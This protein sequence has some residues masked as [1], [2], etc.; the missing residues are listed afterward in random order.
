MICPN[1]KNNIPNDTILCPNCSYNVTVDKIDDSV[2][3]IMKDK[4]SKRIEKNAPEVLHAKPHKKYIVLAFVV[5]LLI[6][7]IMI[8]YLASDTGGYVNYEG[9]LVDYEEVERNYI[10]IYEYKTGNEIKRISNNHYYNN[11]EDVPKTLIISE[12]SSKEQNKNYS[13]AVIF[14]FTPYII[15]AI[16]SFILDIRYKKKLKE[17][18]YDMS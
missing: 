14:I 18:N 2:L 5:I 9:Y 10:G 4:I 7:A 16:I 11:K 8:K 1:C 15:L 13:K 12:Y 3:G 17:N 6:Q